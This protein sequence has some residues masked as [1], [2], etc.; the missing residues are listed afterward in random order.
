MALNIGRKKKKGR[1]VILIAVLIVIIAGYFII[2]SRHH[3]Q[4]MPVSSSE[5]AH[6]GEI[7]KMMGITSSTPPEKLKSFKSIEGVLNIQH[8]VTERGVNVY[9]VPVPTLPMV[10]IEIIFDAGAAR[11]GD[12]GGLA[13]L[14]NTLLAEGTADL[15]ADEVAESFDK[16][17]AQYH[18]ES[19]RDMAIVHLRSLSDPNQ[20]TEAAKTLAAI[21][22]EP[23]FPE[24]GFKREQQNTLS[25]L[26]QQAQQPQQVASRNFTALLYGKQPYANWVLG[27]EDSIQAIT[28]DDIK[29]F[30]QKYYTAKNATVAI[31]GDISAQDADALA[32]ML[33]NHLPEGEKAPALPPVADLTESVN[34]KIEFPSAQTTILMGQ[35]G[36][37]QNDPDYYAL[38]VGNHILGGNGSVTRIFNTIRNQHGLAYSA[39]SYFVPMRVK[40]PFVMACQTRNDQA[41]KALGMMQSLLKE[42]VE[43]GP[44][45][46]E[47]SQAK[48]NLLGGYALQFDSNAAIC[49]EIAALGFYGLPLNHF[50]EFKESV[51]KLTIDDIKKAFEKRISPD[52]L[53]VV[54]VGG[55]EKDSRAPQAQMPSSS[56]DVQGGPG[57]PQH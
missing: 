24:S 33:T 44:T 31:V 36:M 9:F 43:K 8:W 12:K 30:F 35:P 26:K 50:N 3:K 4:A 39:Y 22:S 34:K 23:A 19:Q 53:V 55:N 2:K 10:D 1:W 28:S 13:Y 49:H 46:K 48:Q 37:K 56:S 40:G 25:A 27:T 5:L 7:G 15:S 18:A 54:T 17:G 52:K 47:L 16:V 42:F 45:E 21:L 29:A 11:N 38:A 41:E 57:G 14:T 51:N 32:Q 6:H 20:L